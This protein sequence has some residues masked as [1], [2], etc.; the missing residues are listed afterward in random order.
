[1]L[2]NGT[3]GT[4]VLIGIEGEADIINGFGGDDIILVNDTVDFI[5][6]GVGTDILS[7]DFSRLASGVRIDLAPLWQG[8]EGIM[9]SDAG[10]GTLTDIEGFRGTILPV[11]LT[12]FDDHF[13]LGDIF[14]PS[15]A[16][17]DGEDDVTGGDLPDRLRGQD[18]DDKLSGK[19][20]NDLLFGGS[21]NDK[22]SGGPDEDQISGGVGN[23]RLIGGFGDDE[24]L[25]GRGRDLIIGG[26]GA[27]R[28]DYQT[29][30]SV[31]GKA[32][33]ILGFD[34]ASDRFHFEAHPTALDAA[35]QVSGIGELRSA[36]DA[37]HL[38]AGHAVLAEAGA[39][40]FLVVDENGIAGYQ[41]DVDTVIV[42]KFA[43]H[44][45]AFSMAN[46]V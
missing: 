5:D 11:F 45:E 26:D 40:H 23:D 41:P 43:N 20:G 39:L 22:V 14:V 13:T 34:A 18:G 46:F 6:G 36:L 44:V 15:I 10:D 28:F 38:G 17:G 9:S 16:A 32:D 37:V 7:I 24:F 42:L 31:R 30:D 21:G 25:G 3:N 33:T 4:D 35:V 12:G 2:I 1:M 27:D 29:G 19:G 8:R